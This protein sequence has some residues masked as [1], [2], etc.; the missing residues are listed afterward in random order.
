MTGTMTHPGTSS[1]TYLATAAAVVLAALLAVILATTV[2]ADGGS[3]DGIQVRNPSMGFHS[4][5][6]DPPL[7]VA[8]A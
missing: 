7:S 8:V 1:H 4:D 5:S 3:S 2:F 6:H